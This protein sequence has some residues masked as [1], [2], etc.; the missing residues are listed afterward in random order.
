VGLLGGCLYF[1][2]EMCYLTKACICLSRVNGGGNDVGVLDLF[3][4]RQKQFRGEMPEVYQY[5][6]IPNPLRVQ[7]V[8]IVRDAIGKNRYGND[9]CGRAF[10][11]IHDS[12]CREYGLFRLDER[13]TEYSEAVINFFLSCP[14]LEKSM[15]VI[16]LF[17]QVIDTY[18]RTEDYRYSTSR[19][20]ESDSAIEEL[21][22][23]FKEHGVGFQFESKQMVRVDS[24]YLH[25]EAVK[26]ALYL[27]GNEKRFKGANEEFLKAHEHYRH[28]PE[29]VNDFETPTIRI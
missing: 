18:V 27:L 6:T 21:N 8:H 25:S 29:C 1:P 5:E 11:Y 9:Y 14:E 17:F 13:A 26:P 10:K 15:D 4:K 22:S 12:L 19:R 24:Q 28:K 3:S 16:E 2:Q 23:R 7:I 20:M